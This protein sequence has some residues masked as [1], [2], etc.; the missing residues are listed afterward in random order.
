MQHLVDTAHQFSD[1]GVTSLESC[2][3]L[4]GCEVWVQLACAV[5]GLN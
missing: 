1:L 2:M 3:L 4:L 5:T